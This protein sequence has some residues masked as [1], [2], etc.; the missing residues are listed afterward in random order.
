[1]MNKAKTILALTIVA[2]VLSFNTACCQLNTASAPKKKDI[3][4]Q[5]YSV[6][7]DIKK[8]YAGTVKKVAEMGYTAIEAANYGNGKFYGMSPADFKKSIESLGMKVLSS[9]TARQLTKEELASKDFTAAM[10]WWDEAIA[11]HKVA[12]MKYI[13]FPWMKKPEKL[14]DL[15]TYCEYFNEI[16]KRCNAA[17]LTFLYHNHAF[18]FDKIEGKVMLDY[19]I[20]NTNPEFVSFEMDVYWVVRGQQSPVEYFNR[21]PNRFKLLHIKDHKELGQSGMVGFDAIFNNIE[22]SGAQGIVVE[23]ERYNF[24]PLESVKK[25]YDY[26]N[27][28]DFVK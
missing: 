5:L 24:T 13:G 12:G 10:K 20:E 2:V 27:N 4:L 23:V 26:L 16:G 19:M 21:Y 1:M 7:D 17:G 3:A 11:A 15:K 8:D 9:H 6:R 22:K 25:S 14:A 18:E 28:A